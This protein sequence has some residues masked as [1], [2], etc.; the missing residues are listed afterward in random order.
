MAGRAVRAELRGLAAAVSLLTRLPIGARIHIDEDDIARSLAWLPLV[1]VGL[2]GILALA[3]RV[4]EGRLDVSPTAALI[5]AFWAL[6]TGAIHLDGLA[7]SADGLGGHD[8]AHRL[9][10]MRDSPIGS[11]GAIALVLVLVLKIG[12]VAGVLARGHHLW[13]LAIPAIARAASAGLSVALPYAREDGTGAALVRGGHHRGERLAVA[14][15]TAVVAALACA[16][17][18]G[19]IALAA[20]ALV[21]VAIG[22]LA[23]RRIGGVTGDVLGA[24]I[25]LAECAALL[26]LLAHR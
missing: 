18:R 16:R 21:A 26:G 20:A 11:F 1:G 15:A 22:R 2:G 12:L 24:T 13:L 14:L 17:L 4:L 3:G 9:A 7:D 23:Q 8:R 6:A 19:V 5:V 10:I 25:E